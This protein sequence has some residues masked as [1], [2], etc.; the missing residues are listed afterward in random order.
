MGSDKNRINTRIAAYLVGWQE[1]KVLLGKRQNVAHLNGYWS[2]LAGHVY[3][4]ESCIQGMLREAKEECGLQLLPGELQLVGAEHKHSPPYDYANFI[5]SADLTGH[6]PIN[7]EP[8]KCAGWEFF[9]PDQLPSPMAPWIVAMIERV[10]QGKPSLT[11]YGWD[12]A[13]PQR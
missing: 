12:T 2:L 13:S 3:E 5:F 1:G 8:E 7:A 4:G 10:H 11:V 9:D 6:R